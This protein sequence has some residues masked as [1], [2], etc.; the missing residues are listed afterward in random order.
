MHG[1]R[2]ASPLAHVGR[3]LLVPLDMANPAQV[4]GGPILCPCTKQVPRRPVMHLGR[5]GASANLARLHVRVVEYRDRAVS[6]PLLRAGDHP[7]HAVAQ[8]APLDG[9][10]R[11]CQ[12]CTVDLAAILAVPRTYRSISGVNSQADLHRPEAG[13][14]IQYLHPIEPLRQ[15][16]TEGCSAPVGYISRRDITTGAASWPRQLRQSCASQ[17]NRVAQARVGVNFPHS[18]AHFPTMTC[19]LILR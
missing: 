9:S 12:S 17:M 5:A 15:S 2:C 8:L 13:I 6:P 19:F 11:R 3:D 14:A 7:S 4:S 1:S 18:P 16:E 10:R